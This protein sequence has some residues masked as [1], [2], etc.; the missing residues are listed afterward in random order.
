MSKRNTRDELVS[1]NPGTLSSEGPRESPESALRFFSGNVRT[2]AE[3]LNAIDNEREN[4]L[5]EVFGTSEPLS[6]PSFCHRITTAQIQFLC[7]G[8]VHSIR[9]DEA[10]RDRQ[11]VLLRDEDDGPTLS[12]VYHCSEIA[13]NVQRG[14]TSLPPTTAQLIRIHFRPVR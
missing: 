3:R 11:I 14:H 6:A 9:P 10:V 5:F 7:S 8:Q 2:T 4:K 1:Q 12:A 13:P